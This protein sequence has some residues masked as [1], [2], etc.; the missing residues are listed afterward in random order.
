[1]PLL[2]SN[3]AAPALLSNGDLNTLYAALLRK[4]AA[5]NYHREKLATADS[6]FLY[7]D[8][9]ETGNSKLAILSH[10]LEGHSDRRYIKGMAKALN[11]AGWDIAAWNFRFCAGGPNLKLRM[12]HNG[13]T[14]DLQ[15]VIDSAL[16]KKRYKEIALVGFSM[17]ANISLLHLGRNAQ[18]IPPEIT[19]GVFISVPCHLKSC[20]LELARPRNFLYMKKFLRTMI[21]KIKV[22]DNL[23]GGVLNI[24]NLDKIKTFVE[25]DNIYTG[26]M[27]GFA[28]AFDYY[29]QCSSI[30]EL[31]KIKVP[32]L[33]LS[34]KD[35]PFLTPECFPTEAAQQNNN[36][37]FELS[38]KGGHVGFVQFNK[39]QQYYSEQRAVEFLNSAG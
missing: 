11:K 20:S 6:D 31:S 24:S 1:M 30:Y 21:P 14:D 12:T 39:N 4:K 25:F 17:G 5:T 27:H 23:H 2:A 34:A 29:N 16:S 35:D 19:K 38:E 36:L 37:F 18:A 15:C 33:I 10:G 13:A 8:W 3:Y 22:M 7:C 28:D 32:S 9:L 26:P